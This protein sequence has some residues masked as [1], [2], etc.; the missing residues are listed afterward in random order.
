M[1]AMK[2][3][4]AQYVR[5]IWREAEEEVSKPRPGTCSMCNREGI[6]LPY[7]E[8][9][10]GSQIPLDKNNRNYSGPHLIRGVLRCPCCSGP[11]CSC[12]SPRDRQMDRAL[13][14]LDRDGDWK[15]AAL[16]AGLSANKEAQ[17]TVTF[18]KQHR[19]VMTT[20]EYAA[21]CCPG[22]AR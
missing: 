21:I 1:G 13:A 19:R 7:M 17:K 3:S 6:I 14:V 18:W 11:G 22:G 20:G 12:R 9:P 8:L 15:K 4:H 10:D 16:A 5:R 2:E